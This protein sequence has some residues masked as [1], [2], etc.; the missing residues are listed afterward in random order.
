[1][2][3]RAR[4][5]P[6]K[7]GWPR[8]CQGRPPRRPAGPCPLGPS[9]RV[10]R[11]GT[12]VSFRHHTSH[13]RRSELTSSVCACQTSRPPGRVGETQAGAGT[14]GAHARRGHVLCL[15]CAG[16]C[17]PQVSHLRELQ[18]SPRGGSCPV[19]PELG[20]GPTALQGT[21]P[22]APSRPLPTPAFPGARWRPRRG[23]GPRW[24]S[25]A[26]G[27][28]RPAAPACADVLAKRQ[29]RG[30]R[31]HTPGHLGRALFSETWSV[32]LGHVIYFPFFRIR[33]IFLNLSFIIIF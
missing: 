24:L 29:A 19:P 27:P 8:F 28:D 25:V 26:A 11:S 6:R 22:A 33:L 3:I 5:A 13:T 30:A 17:R 2:R 10:T 31:S 15:P 9:C 12:P 32:P 14:P 7:P 18:P 23:A 4:V 20:T 16:D 21:G 1:M